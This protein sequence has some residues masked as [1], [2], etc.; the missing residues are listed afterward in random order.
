MLTCSATRRRS[1][2]LSE[3]AAGD[4]DL[5]AAIAKHGLTLTPTG[6][7]RGGWVAYNHDYT[8]RG[9][10]PEDA[11]RDVLQRLRG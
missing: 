6:T 4:R 9:P 1:I 5:F 7:T 10:T 3:D 11:V 8:G 2:S